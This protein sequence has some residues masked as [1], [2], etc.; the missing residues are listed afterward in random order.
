MKV[1]LLDYQKNALEILI[2]T[3]STR[4]AAHQ[5]IAD[6]EAWPM[7]RK[8]EHLDYMRHTIQSS[9]EFVRYIFSIQGKEVLN[10]MTLLDYCHRQ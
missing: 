8:L 2:H 5:T 4:L 1:E 9:W 3:K 6:I 10:K 7:E